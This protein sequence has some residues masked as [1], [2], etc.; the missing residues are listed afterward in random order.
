[1]EEDTQ[2]EYAVQVDEAIISL[3]ID[4]LSFMKCDHGKTREIVSLAKERF[5]RGN[6][7]A[8]WLALKQPYKT[9][10]YRKGEWPDCLMR[11]VP[12]N[13]RSCWLIIESDSDD[14]P[15]YRAAIAEIPNVLGECNFFEY[16]LVGENCEWLI[17]DT[18]H[19]EVIFTEFKP[20]R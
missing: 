12:P 2:S 19:N 18:D 6:P 8:W 10:P 13:T 9:Y 16:Y 11:N 20:D 15:V 4:P 14:Y 17:A 3:G 7:R 1:M 5:V